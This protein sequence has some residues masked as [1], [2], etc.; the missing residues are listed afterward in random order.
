[1][2]CMSFAKKGKELRKKEKKEKKRE[3]ERE[4]E[5]ERGKK[6]GRTFHCLRN[7]SYRA[8][9]KKW[10]S[11]TMPRKLLAVQAHCHAEPR[12]AVF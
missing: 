4:R 5:G 10:S 2:V 1:M 9:R 7:Y 8:I 6:K 3:E 12:A 11:Q